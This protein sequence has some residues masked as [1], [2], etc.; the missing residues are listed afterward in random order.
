VILRQIA[1][2]ANRGTS[3]QLEAEINKLYALV[4]TLGSDRNQIAA[5]AAQA[6]EVANRLI[7]PMVAASFDQA[8]T[9]RLIK[10]ISSD[11]DYI[12]AQGERAAEQAAMALDSLFVAYSRNVRVANAEPVRTAIHGLFLQLEDPSGYNAPKF[13]QQ[14]RTVGDLVR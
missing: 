14:M 10:K 1:D 9:L 13:A 3:Q 2:E 8:S 5:Q 11:A 7:Q 4:S 6:S 12:S